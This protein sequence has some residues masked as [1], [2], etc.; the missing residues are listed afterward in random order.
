MPKALLKAW[1][2]SQRDCVFVFALGL[3]LANR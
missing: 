2:N 3:A 1:I